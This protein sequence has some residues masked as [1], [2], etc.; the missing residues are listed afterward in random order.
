LPLLTATSATELLDNCREPVVLDG[1]DDAQED[2]DSYNFVIF[3][4]DILH[5]GQ[6]NTLQSSSSERK[7]M[8]V[9]WH[10]IDSTPKPPYDLQFNPTMLFITVR[11]NAAPGSKKQE[12][13][14]FKTTAHLISLTNIKKCWDSLTDASVQKGRLILVDE[15]EYDDDEQQQ[16]QQ[17]QSKKQKTN[18]RK[19]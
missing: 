6:M 17:Q 19:V 2:C 3:R 14:S 12:I 18:K 7:A 10:V 4:P 13:N 9:S 5:Y 15:E 16:Q 8:F 11:P 1:I